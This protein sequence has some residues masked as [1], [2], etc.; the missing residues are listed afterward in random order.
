MKQLPKQKWILSTLLVAA[1]GSQYYFS[2][3]SLSLGAIDLASVA[4]DAQVQ[5]LVDVSAALQR[6]QPA[7]AAS[8]DRTVVVSGDRS[9]AAPASADVSRRTEAVTP[10]AACSDCVVLTKAEAERMRQILLE[11]T[12]KKEK[13]EEVVAETPSEKRRREREEREEKKR[14]EAEAK[15]DKLR[16]EKLAR[17]EEFAEKAEE[18][19]YKCDGDVSCL[20]SRYSSLLL[21]YSGKKKIDLSVVQAAYRK[22]IDPSLKAALSDESKRESAVEALNSLTRDI[23]NEYRAVKESAINSVKQVVSER[24]ISANNNFKLSEQLS[25]ANK[26][27]ESISVGQQAEQDAA[28]FSTMANLYSSTINTGLKDAGDSA[29]QM[30][31][32]NVFNPEVSKLYTNMR[33]TNSN[34]ASTV[35]QNGTANNPLIN[36]SQ[37]GNTRGVV[38]GGDTTTNNGTTSL[39]GKPTSQGNNMLNGVQ[40]GTP[41]QGTRNGT[42]G[43]Y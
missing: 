39:D 35:N 13:K 5:A 38:R 18:L 27:T 15:A 40:F 37:N 29:T 26:V 42:R 4:P 34:L 23:P 7:V 32:R 30:F 2:T 9:S 11:I 25:K 10:A 20:T 21:R 19:A 17:H 8:G 12:G 6:V 24:A 22:H 16:E 14:E 1:L 36:P 33:L 31:M 41:Q 28:E 3:S 43:S